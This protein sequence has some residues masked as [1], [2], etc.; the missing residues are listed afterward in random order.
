MTTVFQQLQCYSFNDMV[1]AQACDP[2]PLNEYDFNREF[3]YDR[4]F[5]VF[6]VGMSGHSLMMATI[7][8]W[9]HD[10]ADPWDYNDQ[11]G[12]WKYDLE[13]LASNYLETTP[14]TAFE[15]SVRSSVRIMQVWNRASLTITERRVFQR[16]LELRYV[17]DD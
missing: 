2:V 4:R 7:H 12:F 11:L 8:A 15:S 17:E 1:D 6:Q 13:D 16:Y 3:V 10:I 14:G 9:A 5:G